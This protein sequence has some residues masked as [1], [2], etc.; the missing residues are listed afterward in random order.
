MANE[1]QEFYDGLK[2]LHEQ[3]FTVRLT[4]GRIYQWEAWWA[5]GLRPE[6]MQL[7]INH[8]KRNYQ[9]Q[10][11]ET[12]LAFSFLVGKPERFEELLHQAKKIRP[13]KAF[14]PGKAE[15]LKATGRPDEPPPEKVKHISEVFEQMKRATKP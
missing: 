4:T 13:K 5:E 2:A 3:H 9:G 7:V 14:A 8:I 11:R 10:I 1:L 12:M 6:D 15:A